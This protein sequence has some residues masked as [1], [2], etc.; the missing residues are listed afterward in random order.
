MLRSSLMPFAL[1]ALLVPCIALPAR[2]ELAPIVLAQASAPAAHAQPTPQQRAAML[3]QW[4]RAS[5]AQLRSYEW[6]ETTLVSLEGKEKSRQQKR[7]YYGADGVLQKVPVGE[8]TGDSGGRSGPLRRKIAE[9]R[10]E[11]LTAYMKSAVEL[12]Q[13]YVPPDPAAIKAAVQGGRLGVQVLE[14]DRRVRLDFSD[15]KKAGD[16]LGVDIELPTNRLLGVAVNSY[17]DSAQDVVS[18][19]VTMSVLADGTIY[20]QHSVL[21][22]PAGKLSVVVDNSGYR[23]VVQ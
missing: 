5:Q 10:K 1:A 18:L 11:E 6:I 7:C 19:N 17:L 9:N 15:F 8:P 20:A 23:R 16:R 12:V 22:A 13:G 4:M 21:D 14:P 3:E 2:G